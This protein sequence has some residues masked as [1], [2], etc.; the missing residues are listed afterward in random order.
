MSPG[1]MLSGSSKPSAAVTT[2]VPAQSLNGRCQ[3]LGHQAGGVGPSRPSAGCRC[4]VWAWA[5]QGRRR[6]KRHKQ[7]RVSGAL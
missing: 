4:V 1:E 2:E 5:G 6:K 3:Q 7:T